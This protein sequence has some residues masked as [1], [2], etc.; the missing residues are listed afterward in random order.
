MDIINMTIE[1]HYKMKYDKSITM[2]YSL[3]VLF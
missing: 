1:L 3:Y 2:P